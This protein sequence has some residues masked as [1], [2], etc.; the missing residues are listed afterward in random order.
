VKDAQ[1]LLDRNPEVRRRTR[2]RTHSAFS[3]RTERSRT[4]LRIPTR[5]AAIDI[6]PLPPYASHVYP[7]GLN[8]LGQIV[9]YAY[10]PGFPHDE[11][12]VWTPGGTDGPAQNPQLRGIGN[13]AGDD[14]WHSSEA[15]ALNNRG[16]IVGWANG[17][18]Y[19]LDPW[20]AFVWQPGQMTD[21]GTL[22]PYAWG[23]SVARSITDSG[24]IAGWS[25]TQPGDSYS[26]NPHAF[27]YDLATGE[28]RELGVD[29]SWANS[30]NSAGQ[31]VGG[32]TSASGDKHALFWDPVDGFRDLH[33]LVSAGGG[34]SEAA[35]I[36]DRGLLVGWGTDAARISRAFVYDVNTGRAQHLG[37]DGES[38]AF[39]INNS[40]L[41]VAR[42]QYEY[43]SLYDN[44]FVW[45]PVTDT[46]R[47]LGDLIA[48]SGWYPQVAWSINDAGQIAGFA[49]HHLEETDDWL[50]STYRLTAMS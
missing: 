38:L 40:G 17:T 23:S 11:A 39:D 20:H 44:A 2:V 46:A 6:G 47:D 29:E 43:P 37:G 1:H 28:I 26:G 9:G 22:A 13:F 36:N 30:I 41:V 12:V 33:D 49:S 16:Q 42:F 21:L 50:A 19:L 27:V 24:L 14:Y 25:Q 18:D 32:Y 45:D 4:R 10:E 31:V 5:Y 3:E 35:S 7:T 8:E 48:D 34:V 15:N